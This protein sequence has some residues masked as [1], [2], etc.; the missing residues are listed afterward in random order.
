MRK[1]ASL[2]ALRLVRSALQEEKQRGTRVIQTFLN[3]VS[4]LVPPLAR[5][6]G[7]R[8]VVGRR[9]LGFWYTPFG[10][11][12][13]RFVGR[14]VDAYV[15]NSE[16]VADVVR[17]AEGARAPIRII[18]N[19]IAPRTSIDRPAARQALGLRP[20][21]FV[22]ACVANLKPLKRQETAI[23]ALALLREPGS[24]RLVLVGED[25]RGTATSSYRL[26]LEQQA[27]GL[28]VA[29]SVLMTG[30]MPDPGLVWAAADVGLLLSDSEGLSNAVLEGLAASVPMIC[31]AVGQPRAD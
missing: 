15:V 19:A 8:T 25:N 18:P 11:R 17:R 14:H 3:D 22:I 23:A 6:L 31:T 16:A 1:I 7:L 13:L 5:T 21:Q 9:D 12:V 27:S 10:L 30:H 4:F 29:G 2:R 26:E 24:V 28:G 20:D